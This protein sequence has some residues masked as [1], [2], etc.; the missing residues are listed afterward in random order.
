[1]KRPESGSSFS[2]AF[3]FLGKEKRGALSAVYAFCR[4]VDDAV[5]EPGHEPQ[6]ELAFWRQEIGRLYD[7]GPS[8][9]IGPALAGAVKK[10]NLKKEHFLLIVEGAEMDLK[11]SR[12]QTFADLEKYTSR[13]AGAVGLLCAGIFG[14]KAGAAEYA[15]ALGNAVQLT[16]IIRDWAEDAAMGRI[17][18][19]AEDMAAFGAKQEDILAGRLT[20]ELAGVLRF[21]T[22]RA[23][24][25]YLRARELLPSAGKRAMLPA[26]VM[27]AVYGALLDKVEKLGFPAEKT[28]LGAAEK[29]FALIKIW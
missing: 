27:A 10:F 2:L 9:E 18:I 19:P 4:A 23:R 6:A 13:V 3:F 5:D 25:F 21:E 29:I 7:G 20:P 16:N 12:Y 26:S 22:E 28:R 1:M 11:T 17:Y 14:G 24:K 8:S 15:L